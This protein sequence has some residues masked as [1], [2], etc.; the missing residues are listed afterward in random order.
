MAELDPDRRI[1]KMLGARG[2]AERVAE[3]ENPEVT[4]A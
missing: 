3:T 4:V 1:I 2:A